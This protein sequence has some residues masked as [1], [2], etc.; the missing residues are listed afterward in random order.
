MSYKIYIYI[1]MLLLSSF[2]LSGVNF[3]QIIKTN[4]KNEARILA[5][6]LIL[7]LSFTSSMFIINVIELIQGS[8]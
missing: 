1:L 8:L 4:Y 5:F 6:L 3:N 2:A 7:S